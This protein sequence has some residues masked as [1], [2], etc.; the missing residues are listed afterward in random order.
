VFVAIIAAGSAVQLSSYS[1]VCVSR[2]VSIY[3]FSTSECMCVFLI[4]TLD[5]F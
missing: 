4:D 3:I 2:D 1:Q 5:S